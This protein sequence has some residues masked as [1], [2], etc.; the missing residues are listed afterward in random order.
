MGFMMKYPDAKELQ[1]GESVCQALGSALPKQKQPPSSLGWKNRPL[2]WAWTSAPFATRSSTYCLQRLSMAMCSAVWP[3]S[4]K[5][6]QDVSYQQAPV[7]G[8]QHWS[9][10]FTT[11]IMISKKTRTLIMLRVIAYNDTL[12]IIENLC[13][14]LSS[15]QLLHCTKKWQ[16]LP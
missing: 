16:S 5:N 13:Q 15:C 10:L 1:P 6:K 12:Q 14:V 11:K 8:L 4:K 7:Y 3:V 2:A 9:G